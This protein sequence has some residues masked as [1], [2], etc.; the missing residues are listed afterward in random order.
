MEPSRSNQAGN[1]FQL[2]AFSSM[3]FGLIAIISCFSPPTQFFFGAVALM[4]A[5]L[6]K[7]GRPLRAPSVV[8]II[9]GAASILISIFLCAM[10][11]YG[12]RIMDDP[13]NAALVREILEEY[14]AGL[15]TLYPQ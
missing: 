12:V 6:S 2:S 7:Q 11:I 1:L 4:L 14:Q 15:Q 13:A 10:V 3:A 5:Y 9:L 8:G